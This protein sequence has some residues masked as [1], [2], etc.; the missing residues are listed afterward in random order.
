[1]NIQVYLEQAERAKARL[2]HAIRVARRRIDMKEEMQDIAD[3]E[4]NP[5]IAMDAVQK[6]A[7]VVDQLS[8]TEAVDEPLAAAK[9]ALA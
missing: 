4:E 1:M 5:D 2:S 3:D 6:T 7:L 9:A 8:L